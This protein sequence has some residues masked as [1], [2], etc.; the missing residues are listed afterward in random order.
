MLVSTIQHLHFRLGLWRINETEAQ[1]RAVLPQ[2]D[3]DTPR[4]QMVQHPRKRLEK[5]AARACLRAVFPLNNTEQICNTPQGAPF[6]PNYPEVSLSFSHTNSCA[7]VLLSACAKVG[8]DI[9]S[10]DQ[11]RNISSATVFMSQTELERLQKC[12]ALYY[13]IWTAKEAAYKY[14]SPT[15]PLSFKHE[16]I[17]SP[18]NAINHSLTIYSVRTQEELFVSYYIFDRYLLAVITV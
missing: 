12:P 1:F 16:L 2:S 7:A 17:T 11:K 6:L 9:E 13:Y 15:E 10:L 3:F 4:I 5:L 18:F 14:L 8:I